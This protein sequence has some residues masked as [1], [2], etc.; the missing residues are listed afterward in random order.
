LAQT[1]S[2]FEFKAFSLVPEI[3]RHISAKVFKSFRR[4]AIAISN[5]G[6]SV[7]NDYRRIIIPKTIIPLAIVKYEVIVTS[8]AFSAPCCFR[9]HLISNT[10]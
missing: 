8:S 2:I 4:E 10:L 5:Y 1:L 7:T 9:Y 6:N 3:G